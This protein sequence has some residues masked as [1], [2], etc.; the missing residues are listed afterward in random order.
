MIWLISDPMTWDQSLPLTFMK[1][2]AFTDTSAM[3]ICTPQ[4][5]HTLPPNVEKTTVLF[6]PYLVFV[7]QQRYPH[8]HE[9]LIFPKSFSVL[10]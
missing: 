5:R 4:H 6:Y 3:P 10:S 1:S 2:A 9:K 7:E 8:M